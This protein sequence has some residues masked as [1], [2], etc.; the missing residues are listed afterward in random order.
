MGSLNWRVCSCL[1]KA[2]QPSLSMLVHAG[3]QHRLTM[4]QTGAKND[5]LCSC[6]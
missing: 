5:R 4:F 6:D 2:S 1:E 3:E